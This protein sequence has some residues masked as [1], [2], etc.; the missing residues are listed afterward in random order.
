[1]TASLKDATPQEFE[2]WLA[3]GWFDGRNIDGQTYYVDVSVSNLYFRHP[4]LKS[5][6]MDGKD[7]TA[8]QKGRLEMCRR[9]KRPRG[10]EGKPY[11]LPHP[12]S[13]R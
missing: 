5:R 11:V 7:D 12:S 10:K 6:R 1:L 4:E 3:A 9:S 2:R 8:E 13:A